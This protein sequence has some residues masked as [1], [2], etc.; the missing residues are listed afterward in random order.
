MIRNK[1]QRL[2]VAGLL[3]A[4]GMILPYALGHG[5]G[6]PG[7]LLLPMHLPVLLCGFLCGPTYGV[8]CGLTLPVLNSILTG[9]PS[10][11]PMLPIMLCELTVYGL[12][13]GLLFCKT[14]LGKRRFGIYAAL[15]IAMLCGRVA[16]AAAF[17]TI[18]LTVGEFKALT[19]T[20]AI[21]TGLPGILIQLLIIPPILV[22]TGGTMLE[23]NRNAV[24]SAINL[25]RAQKASCAV[26]RENKIVNIEHASGIAPI[27]RM[28]E[29]GMLEGAV[30]VD[31]IVGR[32]A[33]CVMS[34]GGVRACYACTVSEGAV[35]HLK[36]HGIAVEYDQ[37]TEHIV[38]RRGDGPCPME[39]A[40]KGIEDEEDAYRAIKARLAELSER[41]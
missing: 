18:L 41:K 4:I 40:V 24:E 27:L 23:Q 2:T 5:F 19:V 33:A 35:S 10:P 6:I 16:Y 26:I 13:A 36:K 12:S 20:A 38:N 37:C 3:L 30:V 14:P 32:A 8:L 31:K 29:S 11:F 25:I 17:Y 9:M 22:F 28:Y 39:D 7:T 1:T 15:P 21:A 34:L